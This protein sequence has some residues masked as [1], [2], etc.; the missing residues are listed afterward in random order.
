MASRVRSA[1]GYDD[2]FAEA[3]EGGQSVGATLDHLD[4]VDD[5]LGVPVGG[6]LVEVGEQLLAPGA[7]AF[8][9][10]VEGREAG[11]L[12][13]DEKRLESLLGVRSV[14]LDQSQTNSHY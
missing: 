10:R 9:E 4:L 3:S 5:A 8:G 7:D 11:V 6:R 2:A 1:T 14:A 13:R 12:N